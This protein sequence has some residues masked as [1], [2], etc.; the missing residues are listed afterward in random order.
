[1]RA[2]M[3][4]VTLFMVLSCRVLLAEADKPGEAQPEPKVKLPP[5]PPLSPD[6][7][8]K[9]FKLQPG[10]RME[11]IASEPL[12][13]DPVAMTFDGDGRIWAVEFIGYMPNTDGKGEDQP[14]GRVVV[15]ED[16]DGDWKMD[17]RTV[18]LDKLVLPRA[19]SLVKGGVLVA[20]VP[21]LLYCRDTDGDLKCDEQT[22]IATDYGTVGNPE[23]SANGLLSGLDNWIYSADF[24]YRLRYE[25]GADGTLKWM[26]SKVSGK[27]QWGIAQDD[28]GRFYYNNNSEILRADCVP[29]HYFSRNP[30]IKS[31]TGINILAVKDQS[32]WPVRPTP[33]VNRG[34]RSGQLRDD[35]TLA[36]VTAACGPGVYR[37]EQFPE[38]FRGNVFVCEP[39]GN[40]I[41]RTV[42]TEENGLVSGKNPYDKADFLGST[43]ERFRPV[44][45]YTGPDGGLYVVDMYRGI[46]EH[47][48]FLTTFLRKQILERGLDNPIGL[49]R[50]YRIVHEGKPLGAVHPKMSAESS[51]DLLKH[52]E[53]PNAWWRETAQ[54]LL[55]ERSDRTVVAPLRQLAASGTDPRARVHALWALEGMRKLDQPTIFAAMGSDSVQ[56]KANAIRL[57]ESLLKVPQNAPV[58]DKVLEQLSDKRP[59]IQLQL[60][61]TLGETADPKSIAAL[62]SIMESNAANPLVFDAVFSS[63]AGREVEFAEALAKK[64]GAELDHALGVAAN[65][66]YGGRRADRISKLVEL[67]AAQKEVSRQMAM[68]NGILVGT[69]TKGKSPAPKPVEMEAP[70]AALAQLKNSAEKR[71][72]DAAAALGKLFVPPGTLSAAKKLPALTEDQRTIYEHGKSQYLQ[73]CAQC[74]QPTG[75]GEEGKAPPF[76]DSEWVDYSDERLV[77]IVLN[78]I[79]GPVTV[80]G[81]EFSMEMPAVP[82]LD[83]KTVAGC[84]TY[85]RREFGKGA[86][87]EPATVERI[88]KDLGT[89][90]E[91][92]TE[93]EILK[94]K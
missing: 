32:T 74:H 50:I 68:L 73:I 89:R 84:L 3:F 75:A 12:I 87:V 25:T 6:Q 51:V 16:T 8:L 62:A 54:R 15:L 18:F 13:Q 10:F 79:R 53:N 1:M 46:I 14:V 56:V 42:I 77:R 24:N 36:T 11:L 69:A 23:H 22:V 85:I 17:K 45:L 27:G 7:A 39:S 94:I 92:W 83:D 57:C 28:L 31:N 65:C 5:S 86:F 71:V 20:E 91:Q 72:A 37:A 60:A 80:N 43:D 59:E 48:L 33:G 34:Y 64:S 58:L 44:N 40:L 4:I 19:V 61:F 78:G 55:V 93:V 66:V 49:G 21:R 29:S 47:K 41:K 81:R 38:E 76:V 2:S 52:L 35:S 67:I 30:A 88:R 9:S 90:E 70:P 26:R 82:K 63:L